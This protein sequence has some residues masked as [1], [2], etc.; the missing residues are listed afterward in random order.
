MPTSNVAKEDIVYLQALKLCEH[1]FLNK[2][3][4]YN[5]VMKKQVWSISS[6]QKLKS[7]FDRIVIRKFFLK[8]FWIFIGGFLSIFRDQEIQSDSLS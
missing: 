4:F 5:P 1:I 8:A 2:Y 3:A 6:M 7:L